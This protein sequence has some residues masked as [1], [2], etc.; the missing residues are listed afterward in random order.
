MG[1]VKNVSPGLTMWWKKYQN[2]SGMVTRSVSPYRQDL[3]T[4]WVKKWPENIKHKITDNFWDVGPAALL[5]FGTISWGNS[6]YA[7]EMKKHRD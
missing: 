5:F 4:G 1:P 6:T 7:S 3:L 2:Q